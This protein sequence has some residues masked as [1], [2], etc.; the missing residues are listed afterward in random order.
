M[1]NRHFAYFDTSIWLKL[2]VRENGSDEARSLA[3]KHFILSSALLLTECF[4]AL[5]RKKMAG[6]LDARSL[7]RLTKWI[8][9]DVSSLEIIEVSR[10]V[11]G[12]SQELVLKSATRTLDAIHIA[13]AILFRE[14][15]EVPIL[16]AT[17]D[18][19]QFGAAQQQGL[20]ALFVG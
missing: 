9:E 7:Q 16:F 5:S 10:S 12:K 3:K 4:S 1:K 15:I 19:K 6:E 11:L 2:Y 13:S 17:S 14:L 18:R 20:N 8:R